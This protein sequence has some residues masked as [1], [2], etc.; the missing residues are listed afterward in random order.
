MFGIYAF[1]FALLIFG[2]KAIPG[3][4]MMTTKIETASLKEMTNKN[5]HFLTKTNLWN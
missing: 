4:A 1:V 2:R 3:F 5:K